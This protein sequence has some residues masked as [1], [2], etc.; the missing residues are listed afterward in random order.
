M[1][2]DDLTMEKDYELLAN[3]IKQ[4]IDRH[5]N[6]FKLIKNSQYSDTNSYESAFKDYKLNEEIDDV[7]EQRNKYGS[8]DKKV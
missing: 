2:S 5:N 7:E 6:T 1:S 3:E 8:I 4:T